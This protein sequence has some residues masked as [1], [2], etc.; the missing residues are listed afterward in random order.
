[1]ADVARSV[2]GVDIS[3]EA[4]Q[5]ASATYT[6]A[7]LMFRQGSATALDFDDASFDVVVSYELSSTW[8]SK[9]RCLQRSGGYCARWISGYSPQSPIYSEESANI[10]NFMSK[11]LIST[12][13]MN[14]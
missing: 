1:M 13:L 7:N 8:Q 3:N 12:S 9:Q 2:V 10:M 5:H 4:V 11:S 14:C 6:K